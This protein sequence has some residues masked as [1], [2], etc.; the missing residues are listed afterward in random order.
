MK[1]GELEIRE[2]EMDDLEDAMRL[3]IQAGWNQNANDWRRIY[4]LCDDSCFAGKIDGQVVAT[5]T[6]VRYENNCGWIG[7]ML[8][9]EKYRRHGYGSAMLNRLVRTADDMELEWVGLDA[10]EFGEPLYR[11]RGFRPVGGV[12]RWKLQKPNRAIAISGIREYDSI[13][14]EEAVRKLDWAATGMERSDLLLHLH[15]D[16]R[17]KEGAFIVCVQNGLLGFGCSRL[18]RTGPQIGPVVAASVDIAAAIVSALLERL[19]PREEQP[20][21]IDVPRRSA[22]ESWLIEEGFEVKRRLTRMVRG[23]AELGNPQLL[24][25]IAGF[26]YG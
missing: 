20:V 2:M 24:F 16:A 18:R 10:T 3:S 11:K 26:E 5:G 19:N 23:S 13:Y 1:S 9:E 14:D 4:Y 22:I 12:D 6:L 8:V 15:L 17:R 7:M 25:A 21:L